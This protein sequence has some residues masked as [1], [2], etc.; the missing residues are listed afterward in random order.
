MQNVTTNYGS[1]V[2]YKWDD[3]FFRVNSLRIQLASQTLFDHLKDLQLLHIAHGVDTSPVAA[4]LLNHFQC[5]CQQTV[6]DGCCSPRIIFAHN[7]YHLGIM[8]VQRLANKI[9]GFHPEGKGVITR[10]KHATADGVGVE[11]R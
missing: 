5:I 4:I 2:F 11:S 7:G 6:V 10:C 1:D 8:L 9:H 3:L